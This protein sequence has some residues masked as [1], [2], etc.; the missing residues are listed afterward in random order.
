[1]SEEPRTSNVERRT[2]SLP[3]WLIAAV[4]RNGVIGKGND[5]P[6]RYPDD[7]KYFKQKTLGHPIIMGRKNWES[8]K[9]RVLKER[10]N[11][12]V[13]RTLTQEHMPNGVRLCP[14][15]DSAIGIARM[16]GAEQPPFIIGGADIYRQ[17]LP[18][19][20][21]MYL[22]DIP[23]SPDGDVLFPS[24]D[25]HEWY[26]DGR[27]TSADNSLTFRVLERRDIHAT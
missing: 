22:T 7:L 24:Y 6:W 18:L 3:L 2:L 5:L 26:E 11:I 13:S 12:V 4:A 19:V 8:L 17:A 9:G 25:A 23:E 10:P 15:L 27:W 14:D 1:M 16:L 21:R 20:T